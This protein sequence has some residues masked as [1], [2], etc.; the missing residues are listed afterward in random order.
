M[1]R[2]TWFGVCL[3]VVASWGTVC[4]ADSLEWSDSGIK[5]PKYAAILS[6]I[7]RLRNEYSDIA[8]ITDYGQSVQGRTLRMLVVMKRLGKNATFVD[9]PTLLMSGSTHGNEYLNIEDRLPEELLKR[10]KLKGSNVAEFLDRGGAFVFVPIL[11]PDGY[12]G[13]RRENAHG[14]DLNRDW[15]VKPA[16]FKG[17]KEVETRSLATTL[18]SMHKNEGLDFKITVDYHCCIGALLHP[19]AYQEARLPEADLAR[20]QAIGALANKHLNIEVGATGEVLGYLGLGTTKDYY[21]DH[22][23]ALAFTF[24]GRYRQENQN[25]DKHVAWW[26]DMISYVLQQEERPLLISSTM[27]RRNHPFLPLAD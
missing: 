13:R 2:L 21:F 15:D 26:E 23:N 27:K 18:E 14:T 5:G 20:H 11:N 22:Y 7:E 4:V 6:D 12:E 1:N 9:R 16:G 25:F 10:S 19:W 24:E 8:S 3:A 17:F